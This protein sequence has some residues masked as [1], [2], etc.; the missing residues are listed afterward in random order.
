MLVS[1]VAIVLITGGCADKQPPGTGPTSTPASTSAAEQT[2]VAPEYDRKT[3]EAAVLTINDLP[4]GSTEKGTAKSDVAAF[5]TSYRNTPDFLSCMVMEQSQ[6]D[7]FGAWASSPIFTIPDGHITGSQVAFASTTADAISGMQVYR[8]SRF[9]HCALSSMRNQKIAD[10]SFDSVD[11]LSFPVLGDETIAYRI[12]VTV[13]INGTTIH[14][15]QD[16]VVVR[17]GR[18]H[19]AMEFDS[20]DG[21]SF[22]IDKAQELARIV[23]NACR[24]R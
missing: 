14:G 16:P 22:P 13:S 9:T 11:S 3:A 17:A 20:N 7:R 18:A 5:T 4:A 24:S 10:V 8:D 19:V 12:S 1:F 21:T 15:I 23:V 2:R 6:L